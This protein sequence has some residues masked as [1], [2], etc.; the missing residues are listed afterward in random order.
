[1]QNASRVNAMRIFSSSEIQQAF[2]FQKYLS[3]FYFQKIMPSFTH[4]HDFPNLY[5][6][7]SPV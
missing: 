6:F 1:M 5:D 4:P 3:L 7:I 2:L